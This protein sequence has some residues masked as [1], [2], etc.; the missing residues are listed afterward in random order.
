ML[1]VSVMNALRSQ[2]LI[3]TE[4]NDPESV[5]KSL[6]IAFPGEENNDMFFTMWYGVYNKKVRELT[7]ASAGHPPALLINDSDSTDSPARRLRTPNYII[8]GMQDVTYKKSKLHL[9]P[10]SKLFI[11]S[12]G[13]Y[14]IE[15]SDG[16]IWR[17]NEFAEFMTTSRNGVQSNLDNLYNHA[18]NLGHKQK[19]ADDFTILEIDFI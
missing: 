6:N 12:D 1:S 4:W 16:E 2:S 17:Y 14:E 5:M 13:V 8:G 9:G 19:F 7:Y 10:Q 18:L 15:K 3:D 11:F